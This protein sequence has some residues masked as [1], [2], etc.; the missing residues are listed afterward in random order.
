MHTILRTAACVLAAALALAAPASAQRFTTAF[1]PACAG[2]TCDQVQFFIPA[3]GSG[4]E[5]NSLTL[6]LLGTGWFFIPTGGGPTL[7][8]ADDASGPFGGVAEVGAGGT[9]LFIDFLD[10]G[11]PF[12]LGADQQ[13]YLQLGVGNTVGATSTRGLA[14]RY[15]GELAGDDTLAGTVGVAPE[16]VSLALL[17]S[18]LLGVGA[19]RRRRRRTPA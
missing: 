19:L 16:P 13:G 12:T 3:P 8:L 2:G 4:L 14:F 5:L 17:G 15:Q 1:D 18:G 10:S 11:L 7:Y 9:S 6:S